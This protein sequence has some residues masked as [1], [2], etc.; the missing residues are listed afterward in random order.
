MHSVVPRD[1][2]IGKD[3]SDSGKESI[4]FSKTKPGMLLRPAH[5]R[6]TPTKFDEIKQSV[7]VQSGIPKKSGS[8]G[9]KKLDAETAFD[10]DRSV[11]KPFDVD[12]SIIKSI[13]NKFEQA[14]LPESP[15]D[16]AKCRFSQFIL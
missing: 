9:E 5:V 10:S 16:E 8:D 7:A 11:R 6:K 13:S 12:D 4:T 3:Y 15:T 14:L 1:N 2:D